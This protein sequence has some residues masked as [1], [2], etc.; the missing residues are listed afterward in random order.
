MNCEVLPAHGCDSVLTR[1]ARYDASSSRPT[2]PM[3]N[4]IYAIASLPVWYEYGE[5][6]FPDAHREDGTA[7]SRLPTSHTLL[8]YTLGDATI[9]RYHHE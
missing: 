4:C 9:S 3:T 5:L 2:G 1:Q 7:V 8:T 6:D